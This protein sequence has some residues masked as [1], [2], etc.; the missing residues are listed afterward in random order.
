MVELASAA[1]G[2][3]RKKGEVSLDTGEGLD[4]RSDE[5][6]AALREVLGDDYE[7][8]VQGS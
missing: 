1:L 7:N 4:E 8:I 5:D 3:G 2:G 6:D